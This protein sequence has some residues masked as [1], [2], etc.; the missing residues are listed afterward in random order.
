MTGCGTRSFDTPDGESTGFTN[1]IMMQNEEMV[2][3]IWDIARKISCD[4][5]TRMEKLITFRPFAVDMVQ[6]EEVRYSGDDVMCW[7]D[8]QLGKGPFA[9]PVDGIVKIGDEMTI[10][11]YSKDGGADY[12][13]LIK[14]C[15]AYDSQDLE[16]S[17]KLQLSDEQG[18]LLKPKLMNYFL[19]TR[20]TA[21]TGADLIAYA[22]MYAF[23]FPDKMDVFLS[24]EVELCKGGCD[25]IC[26]GA[27]SKIVEKFETTTKP[28]VTIPPPP[29][30]ICVT[31]PS[32]PQC[33]AKNPNNPGCTTTSTTT[34]TTTTRRPRPN[35][36]LL[37]PG[38][39]L[40]CSKNPN[41]PACTT[42]TS[43]TTTRAPDQCLLR[44]GS[45]MCC[46]RRPSHPSCVTTTPN[47]CFL[48]PGTPQ[49]CARNPTNPACTTT[50]TTTTTTTQAPDP[51]LLRPGSIL[52]CARRPTH[53]SCI[54]TTTSTT[55]TTPRTP[56]PNPC[57]LNP[58]SRQCCLRTP[59]NP[60]C[61]TT[62]SS[63]TTTPPDPCDLNPLLPQCCRQNP[64]LPQCTTTTP[65]T[66]TSIFDPC[67]RN[68]GAI[69]CCARNPSHPACT[70]TTITTTPTTT[71]TRRPDLC[72]RNPGS[73]QCCFHKPDHPSCPTKKPC[74][75]N[76]DPRPQCKPTTP[77]APT[78]RD[79]S[80]HA[81]HRG[82]KPTGRRRRPT[83]GSRLTPDV[84][85]ELANTP[86]RRRDVS[87]VA[88]P[89]P[90]PPRTI[91]MTK[92]FRVVGANDLTFR[93]ASS[94]VPT[95]QA[96]SSVCVPTTT[97]YVGLLMITLML[98]VAVLVATFTCLR[99]RSTQLSTKPVE[100]K[101]PYYKQ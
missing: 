44:P 92:N 2:Q 98:V 58:G 97:F 37:N 39:L 40:C 15:Y 69:I 75:G 66:T 12:D 63:T 65:S 51:C 100:A 47:P 86:R 32:L 70:T 68:P 48:N 82:Q 76:D 21:N 50:T 27:P 85:N 22:T 18:C 84:L 26:D 101:N 95:Y 9:N 14:N 67:I 25:N 88:P 29:L 77:A 73:T 91:A 46:G 78:T 57:L 52:C 28:T 99:L 3:E 20:N 60:S 90:P 36:C 49:C 23:K 80:N 19:R 94:A 13:M 8:I 62:T 4:W 33:C 11:V 56:R 93:A 24:C 79:L 87:Y 17:T 35:P 55:T 64:N 72:I 45:Q 43:T 54:T 61:T 5:T 6:A 41:N 53:S 31:N 30:D 96:V 34:T 38:T 7:M 59:N 42:T 89:P 83:Y 81:F 16:S 74:E 71:T 1:M 10:V